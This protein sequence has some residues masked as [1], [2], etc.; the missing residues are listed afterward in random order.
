MTQ[1]QTKK[2]VIT[3]LSKA[4]GHLSAVQRMVQEEKYCIDVLNQLKAVQSALDSCA[5][6]LLKTH[7][8]TT[9]NELAS[10]S[11]CERVIAE[12]WHMVRHTPD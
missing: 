11:E 8:D 10:K 1:T 6:I 9:A 2:L 5:Q 12:L 3:R 4:A 7:L